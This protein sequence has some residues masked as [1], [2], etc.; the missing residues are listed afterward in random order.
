MLRAFVQYTLNVDLNAPVIKDLVE[1]YKIRNKS[2][3]TNI[4]EFMMDNFGNLLSPNNISKPLNN[5]RS[6]ITR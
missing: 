6:E 4:S 2:E 3:F 5:D 1:K